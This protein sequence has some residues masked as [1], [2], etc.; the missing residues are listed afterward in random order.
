MINGFFIKNLV[1]PTSCIVL[2]FNLL[3]YTDN[4]M[5]LLI[6][7]IEISKKIEPMISD[8]CFKTLTLKFISSIRGA[9]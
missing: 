3:E 1:A 4:R 6:K 9:S 8:H 2:I 5:V 7:I